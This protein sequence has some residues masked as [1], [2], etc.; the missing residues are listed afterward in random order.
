MPA[1]L[2]MGGAS[3]TTSEVPR[4]WRTKPRAVAAMFAIGLSS[5][6]RRPISTRSRALCVSSGCLV[7]NAVAIRVSRSTSPGHASASA[8]AS[9]NRMGLRASEIR[10][11]ADAKPRLQASST[12][13]S[14]PSKASTSSRRT[15]APRHAA[16]RGTGQRLARLR[17]FGNQGRHARAI[18]RLIRARE[19]GFGRPALQRA[20]REFGGAQ[21]RD[22]NQRWRQAARIECLQA[23][24]GIEPGVPA[25]A[26]AWR[27]AGVHALHW[28]GRHVSPAS[29]QRRP[30]RAASRPG[31]ASPARPRPPR[32]R[33]ARAPAP[34][35][36]RS[37]GRAP[38]QVTR[39]RM[40]A[41]L[42][43]G[44]AAQRQRRRIVAQRNPLERAQRIAARQGPRGGGDQRV[45]GGRIP[46]ERR[47]L[48]AAAGRGCPR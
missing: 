23:G 31:R 46:P 8:S 48:R 44:D 33:S 30:I 39:Q 20:Q 29:P 13:M 27:Q 11:P 18:R 7:R 15:A 19:G 28:P 38:Q 3:T 1:R 40:L 47:A 25:A 36:F 41:Q 17:H 6:R 42:R 34:R 16:R 12:S 2:S 35:A 9:A 32:A 5:A 22:C 4:G 45:H 10:A 43:H 21:F 26:I 24:G 37:R 14:D